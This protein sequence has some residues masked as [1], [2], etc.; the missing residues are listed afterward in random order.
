M[1]SAPVVL[2]ALTT[3][4]PLAAAA[5]CSAP[6]VV[7]PRLRPARPGAVKAPAELAGYELL[8]FSGG[9]HRYGWRLSNGRTGERVDG[10]ARLRINNSFAVRDAAIRGLGI[11]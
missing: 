11:A 5:I 8:W 1:F 3:R 2:K 6:D 4:A 9:S 7:V 10:A